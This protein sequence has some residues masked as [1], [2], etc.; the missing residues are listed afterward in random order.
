[1]RRGMR[2]ACNSSKLRVIVSCSA[3]CHLHVLSVSV[4]VSGDEHRLRLNYSHRTQGSAM[5]CV[6]S[7]LVLQHLALSFSVSRGKQGAE[8]A[9]WKQIMLNNRLLDVDL[10][11]TFHLVYD[12]MTEKRTTD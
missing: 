2:L 4:C 7:T 8:N 5:L 3:A 10:G 12:C 6:L 1:M 11:G 9:A